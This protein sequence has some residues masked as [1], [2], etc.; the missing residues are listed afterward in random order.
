MTEWSLINLLWHG[1]P[2]VPRAAGRSSETE[3]FG[4]T[5]GT[6]GRPCHNNGLSSPS[7]Y[8]CVSAPL[9]FNTALSSPCLRDSVVHYF[10]T[11]ALI[12]CAMTMFVAWFTVN[13]VRCVTA[14]TS[15]AA[16]GWPLPLRFTPPK[17][18]CTSA[19]MQGKFT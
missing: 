12:P 13:A 8:I 10:L 15:A 19:P 7:L 11:S 3:T 16:D 6:V 5:G 1:L 17:G 18:R 9:R 2:T 14:S 4:R